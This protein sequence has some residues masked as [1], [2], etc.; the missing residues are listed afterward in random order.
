MVSWG[1][2]SILE[3]SHQDLWLSFVGLVE[4]RVEFV[5]TCRRCA[6]METISHADRS[7]EKDDEAKKDTSKFS[8]PVILIEKRW[9][10]HIIYLAVQEHI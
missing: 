1:Q 2:L 8:F 3:S 5:W 6:A 9:H 7:L 4:S 10:G